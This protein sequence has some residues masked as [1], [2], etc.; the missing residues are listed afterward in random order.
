MRWARDAGYVVFTH[1]LDFGTRLA[2][3][4]DTGPS[5]LQVRTL[6]VLP[7]AIGVNVLRVLQRYDAEPRERS[8]GMGPLVR[9]TFRTGDHDKRLSPGVPLGQAIDSVLDSPYP[10]IHGPGDIDPPGRAPTRRNGTRPLA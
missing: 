5:V 6:D 10:R 9:N 8:L 7:H 1:D 4:G 2:L 3:A